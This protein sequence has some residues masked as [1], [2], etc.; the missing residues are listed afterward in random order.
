MDTGVSAALLRQVSRA[1]GGAAIRLHRTGPILAFGRLDR[2]RPG[3]RRAIELARAHGYEPV[4]RLAGGRAAVF[5]EGTI[6]FSQV[7]PAA[8]SSGA[9]RGTRERFAAMAETMVAALSELSIDAR[10]GEVSGEYCPGE[11]SVNARGES[12]LAGIGQRVL[13]GGAHVGGVVVVRGAGRIRT[14][15]EPIYEALE[16]DWR[17]ATTGSIALEI[18]DDDETIP[19]NRTD[20]LIERTMAALRT[21]LSRTYVLD[22]ATLDEATLALAKELADTY[23]PRL[24][25]D[26]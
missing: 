25:R 7:V 6:S 17:P 3:Y 18:G 4:E 20:P 19:S 26:P 8:G 12:K 22:D 16:L 13:T 9:Y 21:T 14:V 11:F 1:E 15:L 2:L 24:N 23:R 5:H 10:I